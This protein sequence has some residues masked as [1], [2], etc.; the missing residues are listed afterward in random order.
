[1]WDG[2]PCATERLSG[3]HEWFAIKVKANR[4][5]VTAVALRGR[6]YG[7]FVPMYRRRRPWSNRI[8]EMQSPLFPGYVFG[9]FDAWNRLPVL[10]IP[11]VVGI[12]GIGRTPAPIDDAEIEALQAVVRSGAAAEPWPF[13]RSGDRVLLAAGP[14]RGMEGLFVSQKNEYRLVV[15]VTLL[16]RSIAVVID[17][18]W[19]VPVENHLSYRRPAPTLAA[20]AGRI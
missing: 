5:A 6:G 2:D 11:G 8:R 16:Q 19:V 7:E 12:V 13:L 4:E 20:C 1:M 17:R 3:R 9:R 14:L 10:M 15:S 18:R